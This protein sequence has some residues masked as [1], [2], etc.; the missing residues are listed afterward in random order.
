MYQNV[1]ATDTKKC[2]IELFEDVITNGYNY[3]YSTVL[4]I[5]P[6]QGRIVVELSKMLNQ[7]EMHEGVLESGKNRKL[8]GSA[9]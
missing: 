8:N 3:L 6:K 4:I 1:R 5:R 9:V 7:G 2:C